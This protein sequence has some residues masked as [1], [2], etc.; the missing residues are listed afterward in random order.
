MDEPLYCESAGSAVEHRQRMKRELDGLILSL[1]AKAD[2]RRAAF[3]RPDTTSLPAYQASTVAYRRKLRALLGWPLRPRP[4]V[5]TPARAEII[6]VGEDHLGT[7]TRLWISTLPGVATYGVLFIPQAHGPHGPGPFPLVI[8]Q[9]GGGGTPELCSGLWGSSANYNDM[10]RRV[11]RRGCAVFAPQLH[12]W[13]EAYQPRPQR[14][15]FNRS[16]VQLGGSMAALEVFRLQRCL[17][18]LVTRPE[19]DGQRIGMIGLSYGGFYTLLTAALDLRI[20]AALSSCF[21]NNRYVYNWHDWVWR[22]SALKFLDAEMG[23]L[24]CPRHLWIE[25]GR[26]DNLFAIQHVGSEAA[27]IAATYAKLDRSDHF[28]L[29]EFDGGHEL[30]RSDDGVEFLCAALE[31]ANRHPQSVVDRQRGDL[32]A[33]G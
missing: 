23:Q 2:Q 7:I 29:R 28:H 30:D 10:T 11:L 33:N 8:S 26:S 9:H 17:D 20:K 15:E 22:G 21:L 19:I 3:F 14:E 4:D 32:E 27:K 24:I 25:V 5:R 1:R 12:L 31:V 16:L 13:N 18:Y 6:P